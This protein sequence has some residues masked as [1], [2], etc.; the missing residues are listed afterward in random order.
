VTLSYARAHPNG[1]NLMSI[2]YTL[3]LVLLLL[4]F[5]VGGVFGEQI[6]RGW[7]KRNLLDQD[8]QSPGVRKRLGID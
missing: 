7:W 6:E 1:E 8:R 2:L 3:G 5:C 4:A